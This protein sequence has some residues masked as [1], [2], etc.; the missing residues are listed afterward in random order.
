MKYLIL[1]LTLIPSLLISQGWEKTYGWGIGRSVQQSTDGGYIITGDKYVPGNYYDIYLIKTDEFGDTLW[2]RTYDLLQFHD[3]GMSI[4]K[5]TDNGYIIT[6]S[7]ES[8]TEG[9][10]VYLLKIDGYGDL[11]W[12]KTYGGQNSDYARSVKQVS[13][14]GYIVV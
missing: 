2:T 4:Q 12:A 7:T 1:I 14:E 9:R 10:D 8:K 5:T 11:Q 6:G 3:Y 13:D